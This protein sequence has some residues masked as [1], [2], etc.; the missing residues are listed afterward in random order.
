MMGNLKYQADFKLLSKWVFKYRLQFLTFLIKSSK[1][2][3]TM[4]SIYPAWKPGDDSPIL[5]F[6]SR[7]ETA[8]LLYKTMAKCRSSF[9]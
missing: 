6:H 5:D 8:M 9:A 7:D 4:V 3:A 1:W 2:F